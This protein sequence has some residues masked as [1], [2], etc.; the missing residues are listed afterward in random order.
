MM[1]RSASVRAVPTRHDIVTFHDDTPPP[2]SSP[3]VVGGPVTDV[4]VVSPDP[5]WP[6]H[7]ALLSDQIR[8]VLGWRALNIEHVGSTSVPDLAAKPIIDIDLT[9]ADP[10]DEASYVPTLEQIGFELRVREP[11]WFEHRLLKK[12]DPHCHL[13]VFG[14]DSPE[15]VKHRIFRDWL[16]GNPDEVAFYARIKHEAAAAARKAGEHS[17]QYNLR[18]QEGVRDI[19]DRAFLAMGLLPD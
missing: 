11:W 5:D 1:G 7:F 2:G 4:A 10:A 16:R 13:H 15:L 18:K 14:Y 3:W 8:G 6:K 17:M 19:Y 9:V 12:A